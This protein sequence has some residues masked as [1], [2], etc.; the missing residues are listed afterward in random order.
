M[1]VTC[2]PLSCRYSRVALELLEFLWS[3][4]LNSGDSSFRV[5]CPSPPPPTCV[6]EPLEFPS[7][8]LGSAKV[9]ALQE[10]D[11]MLEK[12]DLELVVHL[13]LGYYSRLFLVQKAS[14]GCQPMINF[15]SLN[16][17]VTYIKFKVGTASSVLGMVRKGGLHVRD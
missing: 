5:Y 16:D 3:E 13:G 11:R 2:L 7:Y 10:V 8:A 1:K 14:R 12:N 9:Q 15:S 6:A 17:C 4:G